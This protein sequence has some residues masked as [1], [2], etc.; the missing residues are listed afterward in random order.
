MIINLS[1][2]K[3]YWNIKYIIKNINFYNNYRPLNTQDL[4]DTFCIYSIK[5][6]SDSQ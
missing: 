2:T 1:C 3:K 4:S 6:G 5:K